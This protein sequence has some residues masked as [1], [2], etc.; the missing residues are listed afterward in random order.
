VLAPLQCPI[1]LM[2]SLLNRGLWTGI[3][4][5]LFQMCIIPGGAASS[6]ALLYFGLNVCSVHYMQ[7]HS[8]VYILC[9]HITVS[10]TGNIV[11]VRILADCTPRSS[12]A[13][14]ESLDYSKT[15]GLSGNFAFFIVLSVVGAAGCLVFLTL[16]NPDHK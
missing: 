16:R 13:P 3:F 15:V 11:A 4:W 12:S 8:L 14:I 5:G 6:F 1:P 7:T 10:H 9:I 2:F